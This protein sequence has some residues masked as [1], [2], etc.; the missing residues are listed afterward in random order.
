MAAMRLLCAIVAVSLIAG[1]TAQRDDNVDDQQ[2][3]SDSPSIKQLLGAVRRYLHVK[4]LHGTSR[5]L[6]A[7]DDVR[8]VYNECKSSALNPITTK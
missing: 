1:S 3:E 7:H 5:S 6:N 4:E 8:T 2:G